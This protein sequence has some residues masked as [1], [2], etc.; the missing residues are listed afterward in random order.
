VKEGGRKGWGVK[1]YRTVILATN[2]TGILFSQSAKN[3]IKHRGHHS[4]CIQHL[5]VLVGWLLKF[6]IHFHCVST[7][8]HCMN[9][10]ESEQQ[11]KFSGNISQV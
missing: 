11:V 3:E 1:M 8:L 7:T 5:G 9:V 10:S 2:L 6:K 4:L